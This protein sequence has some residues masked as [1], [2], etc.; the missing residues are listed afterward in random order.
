[1]S[2]NKCNCVQNWLKTMNPTTIYLP[3][4]TEASLQ[5]LAQDTGKTLP[6]LIQQVINDYLTEKSQKLPKSVGM[7]ASG[8]S[9]L[10]SK[11]EELLWTED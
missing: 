6:E 10:S 9:D 1:M 5:E 3:Q 4:E 8:R 2:Y 11:T 7:G